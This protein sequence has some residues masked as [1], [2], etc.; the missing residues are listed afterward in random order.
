[1]SGGHAPLAP[2]SAPV[3][4]HCSGSVLA[5]QQSPSIETQA[6]REGTAAHWVGSE[7]LEKAIEVGSGFPLCSDWVGKV[8]P[9]G[10][11]ISPEMTDAAQVYVSDVL[12]V[13]NE[14]GALRSLL[15]E[16]KVRMPSIHAQNYGTLDCGLVLPNIRTI[17]LWDY[18]HGHGLVEA[19]A[20][21]QGVDY[22][23]GLCEEFGINGH[24]DQTIRVIVRIA[25]PRCYQGDGPVSEWSCMLSDIRPYVNQ[26]T[27]KAHEA[28]T[29]PTLTSG[30]HCRYCPALINCSAV[31]GS[32]YR[33]FD[34][35]ESPF[36]IDDMAGADLAVERS[37]LGQGIKI[38]QA[39]LDAID[40][41]LHHDICNGDTSSGLTLQ[42]GQGRL[43]WT[44]PAQEVIALGTMFGLDVA[45]K[46]AITP[47][48][49]I[50]LA[51]PETRTVFEQAINL[52]ANRPSSGVKLVKI[53]NSRNAKAFAKRK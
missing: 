44:A 48:Q 40:E 46:E 52:I 8:A 49:A 43:K 4:G 45:K 13:A 12:T 10:V 7:C 23:E 5:A 1:M 15:I 20:N 2:S 31:R 41:Q 30:T 6:T 3:W 27:A 19:F 28:F 24:D 42:A 47:T 21:L 35:V 37:I 29:N 50:A 53:E 39:R 36:V 17:Y 33:M 22:L 18:K 38:A 14:H 26:L 11:V 32:H 9:N 51:P 25:Q 16:H 34:Y